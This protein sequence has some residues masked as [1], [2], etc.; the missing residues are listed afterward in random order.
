LPGQGALVNGGQLTG[1]L[2][3]VAHS[4]MALETNAAVKIGQQYRV[5]VQLDDAEFSATGRVRWCSL[6]RT[7][8]EKGG[9]VVPIFHAG[10]SLERQQPAEVEE[11]L[12]RLRRRL[13]KSHSN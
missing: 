12:D 11:V 6:R 8:R 10:L 9:E 5:K 2:L 13:F 3:N 4:G 7:R 1:T